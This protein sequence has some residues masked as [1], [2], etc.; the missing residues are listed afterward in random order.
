MFCLVC[1]GITLHSTLLFTKILAFQEDQ[2]LTF[3]DICRSLEKRN[4]DKKM[5]R[6]NLSTMPLHHF[7]LRDIS[8]VRDRGTRTTFSRLYLRRRLPQRGELMPLLP[9]PERVLS[10]VWGPRY[11]PGHRGVT[12]PGI[13][14]LDFGAGVGTVW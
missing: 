9:R 7:T 12:L 2:L 10:H 6:S 4:R 14:P 8:P 3:A 11:N 1:C 5:R 13:T